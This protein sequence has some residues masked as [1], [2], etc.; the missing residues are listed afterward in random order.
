MS[1]H[2]STLLHRL[3]S[4][5]YEPVRAL[6]TPLR[7][8]LVID[9]ILDGNTHG[10]VYADDPRQPRT[11]VVWNEMEAILF[12]GDPTDQVFQHAFPWL[13]QHEFAP[14]AGA[15]GVPSLNLHIPTTWENSLAQ[16][17]TKIR[18]SQLHR[19]FHRLGTQ[20]PAPPPLPAGFTLHP[21][22]LALLDHGELGNIEQVLAWIY[23]FW[24]ALEDLVAHG[25]GYY[26]AREQ[27]IASWCLTVYASG[28]IV[29]LGVATARAYRNHGLATAV[30]AACVA[31][32]LAKGRAPLWHC[33]VDNHAS[34]AVARHVGFIP[35]FD[36]KVYAF[37]LPTRWAE[38]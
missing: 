35:A 4:A 8:N 37:D 24:S 16:W 1:N 38:R 19:R 25:V 30:A 29:E 5:D 9:S 11:A 2:E 33:N 28:S 10:R 12:A 14:L 23:S 27:E 31:D 15:K 21:F 20:P 26:I 32:C 22:D 17:Q 3:S 18:F 6:F 36:Y 13:L 34:L 7:Y